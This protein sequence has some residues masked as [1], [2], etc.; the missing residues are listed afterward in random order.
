MEKRVKKM[1]K[2]FAVVDVQTGRV[3]FESDSYESAARMFFAIFDG[4]QYPEDDTYL[5]LID[6]EIRR[7]ISVN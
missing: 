1:S 6:N 3:F 4:H 2:K 7:A 5:H